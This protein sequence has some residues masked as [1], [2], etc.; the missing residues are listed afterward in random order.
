MLWIKFGMKYRGVE[1]WCEKYQCKHK[2]HDASEFE[3]K[4]DF[5]WFDWFVLVTSIKSFIQSQAFIE[6]CKNNFKYRTII[7]CQSKLS[8]LQSIYTGS[9][10]ATYIFYETTTKFEVRI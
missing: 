5:C 6:N 3:I 7:L 2:L 1:T 10:T 4:I 9:M 8:Y